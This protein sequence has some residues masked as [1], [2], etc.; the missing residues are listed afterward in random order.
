MVALLCL[1]NFI[2]NMFTKEEGVSATDMKLKDLR[3][4]AVS[5]KLFTA[6][7][8]AS[9][10]RKDILL[11]VHN[12]EEEMLNDSNRPGFKRVVKEEGAQVS[13]QE[14]TQVADTH[15]GKKVV[16]RTPIELNGKKYIDILVESG[17]TYREAVN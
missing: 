15:E 8:V 10:K 2:K 16:T 12:K 17:E 14:D 7:E 5:L 9:M 11:A 4:L 6:E 13:A 3:E 1:F